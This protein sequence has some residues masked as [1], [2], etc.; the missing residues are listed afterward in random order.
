MQTCQTTAWETQ[1]VGKRPVDD[2]HRHLAR[3][4][5][6]DRRGLKDL[7]DRFG[8][9]IYRYLLALASDSQTAEEILQDTLVAVWRSA[10]TYEGR[11]SVRTWLFGV[12]RRQAHN[13]LRRKEPSFAVEEELDALP[14]DDSGPEEILLTTARKHEIAECV[15]RLNPMHREVLVLVFYHDLSYAE[16]AR[17]LDA[18]VGTIKSRLNSAKRALRSLLET[19]EEQK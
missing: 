19:K 15:R 14:S 5:T 17:V 10:G 2:E 1:R 16:T 4:A 18:P 7:Y 8:Q 9:E 6:G 11:S 13:R 3:V 12:A